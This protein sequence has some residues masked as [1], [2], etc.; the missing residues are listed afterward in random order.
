[1]PTHEIR[2]WS[3]SGKPETN[4][5]D[6]VRFLVGDTDA[7]NQQLDDCEVSYLLGKTGSVISAAICAVEGLMA[8]YARDFTGKFGSSTSSEIFDNYK[9]LYKILKDKRANSASYI[10]YS[11]ALTISDKT[12]RQEDTDR[13]RPVFTMQLNENPRAMQPNDRIGT[14]WGE[15]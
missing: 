3:Y 10:A 8:I 14:D 1:M 13:V 5:K 15:P 12:A 9:A 4:E 7:K 6:E 11:G 2:Q